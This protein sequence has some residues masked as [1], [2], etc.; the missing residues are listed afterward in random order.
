[1]E[2]GEEWYDSFKDSLRRIIR[3]SAGVYFVGG[4]GGAVLAMTR[5]VKP[6]HYALHVGTNCGL[7]ALTCFV[8]HEC[9]VK[10]LPSLSDSTASTLSGAMG[11]AF[12]ML[13]FSRNSR[14]AVKGACFF[15]FCGFALEKASGFV[16]QWKAQKREEILQEQAKEWE[17]SVYQ[18]RMGQPSRRRRENDV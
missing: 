14:Q 9:F 17:P 6:L 10:T 3:Q 4:L 2:K 18:E 12:S 11:G 1:M 8:P 5:G 15:G 16:T 7:V 13:V